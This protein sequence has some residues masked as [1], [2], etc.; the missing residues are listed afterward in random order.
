M[1]EEVLQFQEVEFG[2]EDYKT[3]I[4]LRDEVLRKPL[5]L[6]YTQEQLDAEQDSWHLVCKHGQAVVGCLILKPEDSTI[7]RMR[8]FAVDKDFQGTG[9]GKYLAE[10]AEGLAR[11]RGFSEIVLNA[12]EVVLGFYEKQGY[13]KEGDRFIEV[14]I[15]HFRM[16]KKL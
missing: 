3:A 14:T 7:I 13:R 16:R 9:V 15:P 1:Q 10:K 8:Q 5:G 6:K 12:R 11:E 2:S 4:T